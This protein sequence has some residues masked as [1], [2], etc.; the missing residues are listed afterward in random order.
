MTCVVLRVCIKTG[1]WTPIDKIKTNTSIV[2]YIHTSE[3]EKTC[4]FYSPTG[5]L[6]YFNL[7]T[8]KLKDKFSIPQGLSQCKLYNSNKFFAGVR[9]NTIYVIN[10]FMGD[11]IS[12]IN[13]SNPII[14]SSEKDENLYYLENDGRG[15]YELKMLENLDNLKVSNPRIV[16]TLK[17]PRSSTSI[18]TG[19]KNGNE[20]LLGSKT[21]NIYKFD[22]DPSIT[23][24]NMPEI[25]E[26]I[27]AKIF[28]MCPSSSDFYFLTNK[29]IFKSSY[30]TGIVDKLCSVSNK[31]NIIPYSDDQVILYSEY[32]N[33]PVILKNISTG[34]EKQLFVPK[35][36]LHSLKLCT[37]EGKNK[38]VEL[39]SS[40]NVYI[41][42]FETEK[43]SEAYIGTGIQDAI[44][45]DA[46]LFIA[47]SAATNPKTPLILMNPSTMETVPV[48]IKGNVIY[49][50]SYS[51][52]YLYG[53]NLIAN[54]E[55]N[56]TYVFSYDCN[57]KQM[58]NI[59]KFANEDAEAFTYVV[60]NK[61]FTNIG[62]NKIYSYNINTKKIFSYNRSASI[63]HK[64]S[65]N[66]NRVVIL[67]SNGSISWCSD[68]S[69]KLLADWYLTNDEQW[70]EF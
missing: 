48:G 58:K 44:L 12:R 14:L 31:T 17:G 25:T 64:I 45:T 36:T 8:G 43:Y 69:N 61:L 3:S 41:Y 20:I 49:G 34:E 5:N 39:E 1:S 32:T 68:S 29:A 21:G 30:D 24:T 67:N 57:T 56:T 62:K 63:P 22:S 60:N 19:I 65:I 70:Y 52:G 26:N 40:S 38:L 33:A 66:G 54:N 42:D 13:A 15:N 18:N 51:N 9:D 16:K 28:D 6:S 11:T 27:Y 50:L 53:V 2:N 55:E 23:T 59:L 37:V 47:K 35:N 4:V 46:G 7:T 10:A